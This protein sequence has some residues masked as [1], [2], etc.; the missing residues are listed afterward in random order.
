MVGVMV[1][2]VLKFPTPQIRGGTVI[3]T[4]WLEAKQ[5]MFMQTAVVKAIYI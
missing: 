2:G 4:T 5:T 3:V 1:L